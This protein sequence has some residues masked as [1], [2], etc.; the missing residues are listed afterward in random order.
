MAPINKDGK[1]PPAPHHHLH[2]PLVPPATGSGAD[3]QVG[4][5]DLNNPLV[6]DFLNPRC[7]AA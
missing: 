1:S 4:P 6:R 3:D 2:H 7:P 5:K